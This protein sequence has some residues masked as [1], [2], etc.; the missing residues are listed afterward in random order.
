M[1]ENE[2]IARKMKNEEMLKLWQDEK[3]TD[4]EYWRYH[5]YDE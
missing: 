2:K 5:G 4:E 1:T 3:I